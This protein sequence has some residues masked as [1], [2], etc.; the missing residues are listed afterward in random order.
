MTEN[1][2]RNVYSLKIDKTSKYCLL[3]FWPDSSNSE[4]EVKRNWYYTIV[5]TSLLRTYGGVPKYCAIKPVDILENTN[6]FNVDPKY[7]PATF[8]G[9]EYHGSQKGLFWSL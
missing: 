4:D 8:E 5:E 9:I 6:I 1:I 2:T 3:I 7:K